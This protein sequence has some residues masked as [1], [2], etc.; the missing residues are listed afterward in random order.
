MVVAAAETPWRKL[1]VRRARFS[2]DFLERGLELVSWGVVRAGDLLLG[3]RKGLDI[4]R[5]RPR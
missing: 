4:L 2:W 5:R 3:W 1:T